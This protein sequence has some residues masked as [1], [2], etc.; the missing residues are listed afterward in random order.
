MESHW[1]QVQKLDMVFVQITFP[2]FVLTFVLPCSNAYCY[3]ALW[4]TLGLHMG[5]VVVACVLDVGW[6]LA[7]CA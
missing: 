3:Y 2:I 1:V 7:L 6:R 4:L 5:Q